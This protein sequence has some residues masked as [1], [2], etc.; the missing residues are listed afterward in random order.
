MLSSHQFEVSTSG[1]PVLEEGIRKEPE[2]LIENLKCNSGKS[3]STSM[4][5]RQFALDFVWGKFDELEPCY[6]WGNAETSEIEMA[7]E[8]DDG[9]A[10]SQDN[11]YMGDCYDE[12][13]LKL[14]H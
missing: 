8:S 6:A 1:M 12:D 9:V 3:I 11:N 5:I 2:W 4:K 14:Y 10:E 7:S 13:Y